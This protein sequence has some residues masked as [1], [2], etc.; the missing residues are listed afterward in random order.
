MKQKIITLLASAGA[1]AW[2]LFSTHTLQHKLSIVAVGIGCALITSAYRT[3]KK[4]PD[5]MVCKG[6]GI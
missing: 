3:Y 5:E 6:G 2:L 1:I 4:K